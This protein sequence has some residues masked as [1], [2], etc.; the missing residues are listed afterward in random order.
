MLEKED[1][2]KKNKEKKKEEMKITEEQIKQINVENGK[3]KSKSS[4]PVNIMKPGGLIFN[5]MYFM[6]LLKF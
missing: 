6:F 5:N 2:K 4:K 1:E 3:T